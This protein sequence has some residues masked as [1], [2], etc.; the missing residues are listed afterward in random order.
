MDDE[1][2][3]LVEALQRVEYTSQ[4]AIA[5]ALGW[6]PMKVS[7]TKMAAEKSGVFTRAQFDQ[8][9]AE[10]KLVNEPDAMPDF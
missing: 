1:V 2:R 4:R 3:T 9:I 6:D 7:R 8:W 5:A 10:A